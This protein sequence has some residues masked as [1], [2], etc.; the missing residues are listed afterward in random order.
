[1]IHGRRLAS[2]GLAFGICAVAPA[3]VWASF[4]DMQIEQVIG[5]VS[6]DTSVQAIQLR[7]SSANQNLVSNARVLVRDAGGLNPIIV[8]NMTT[9]VVSGAGR[10]ILIAT[11]NL[12]SFTNPP[13]T[14]DFVITNP[15]PPSY[16]AAGTLTFESDT[17]IIYWRLS[18]G[19]AGYTGSG[20]VNVFNDSDGNANP[21]F[22]GPLPS[23]AAKFSLRP[24][25]V[26]RAAHTCRWRFPL[27][28]Q[29]RRGPRSSPR[30]ARSR[31]LFG[32]SRLDY[33]DAARLPCP[34][35]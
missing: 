35:T 22:P 5:G 20:S 7:M 3:E 26:A 32:C 15:I 28:L 17:G 9:N 33:R 34:H 23:T 11:A 10:R 14:P 24:D 27:Q 13:L 12:A 1:M 25:L 6:G 21:P 30:R 8:M 16:M 29:R 31:A 2:F 18:W 4:H 19:G